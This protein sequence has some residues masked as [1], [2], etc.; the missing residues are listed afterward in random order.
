M[1]VKV[2]LGLSV[3]SNDTNQDKAYDQV[4]S[5]RKSRIKARER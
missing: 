4:Y 1:T 2:T 5:L 3:I